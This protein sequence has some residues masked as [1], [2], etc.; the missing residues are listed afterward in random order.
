MNALI[1]HFIVN[2]NQIKII[3][4]LLNKFDKITHCKRYRTFLSDYLSHS[5]KELLHLIKTTDLL[6]K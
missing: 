5:G 1:F 6:N 3:S 4:I 2:S